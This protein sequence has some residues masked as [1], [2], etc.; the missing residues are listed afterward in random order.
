M[1]GNGVSLQPHM[2]V[3]YYEN[4]VKIKTDHIILEQ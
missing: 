1:G 3:D 2:N 4:G